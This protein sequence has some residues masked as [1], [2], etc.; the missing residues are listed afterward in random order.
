MT[1]SL[2]LS[3][4]L[5]ANLTRLILY[6]SGTTITSY[7]LTSIVKSCQVPAGIPTIPPL[8][9]ALTTP[10]IAL[11]AMQA[12]QSESMNSFGYAWIGNAQRSGR[13][14]QGLKSQVPSGIC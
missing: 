12:G 1:L 7:G 4:R 3:K 6:A 5:D 13:S 9:L 2:K 10:A 11:R 14:L 8:R